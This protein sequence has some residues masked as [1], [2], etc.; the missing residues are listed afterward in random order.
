MLWQRSSETAEPGKELFSKLIDEFDIKSAK[1][2]ENV[3]SLMLQELPE[4]GLDDHLGYE[5][6]EH[7]EESGLNSRNSHSRK[8][9]T[10]SFGDMDLEVPHELLATRNL[11]CLIERSHC[12]RTTAIITFIK[13]NI[14]LECV[15]GSTFETRING[16]AGRTRP[17]VSFILLIGGIF[18][19]ILVKN[20]SEFI[21]VPDSVPRWI[22]CDRSGDRT[23]EGLAFPLIVVVAVLAACR[24]EIVATCT[25]VLDWYAS[26]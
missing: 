6:Y 22:T 24:I 13:I 16:A 26:P 3:F 20:Y 8:K 4:G 21:V 18:R 5:K 9:A 23:S 19:T 7:S 1:Y 15:R 14:Q 10:T 12:E 2:I 11:I 25:Y 17:P